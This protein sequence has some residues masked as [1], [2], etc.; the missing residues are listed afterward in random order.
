M[1]SSTLLNRNPPLFYSLQIVLVTEVTFEIFL[2]LVLLE[3]RLS[4]ESLFDPTYNE[5]IFL[6]INWFSRSILIS[7]CF[8]ELKWSDLGLNST[9]IIECDLCRDTSPLA[10]LGPCDYATLLPETGCAETFGL[11]LVEISTSF[12]SS[13]WLSLS[14]SVCRSLKGKI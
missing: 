5:K 12:F 4:T 11:P 1:T 7:S 6:A 8:L 10:E 9:V 3:V 13:F 14:I 2:K